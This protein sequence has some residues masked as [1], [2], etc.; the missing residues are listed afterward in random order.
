[1]R[2]IFFLFIHLI[3]LHLF[4]LWYLS[5]ISNWSHLFYQ[6]SFLCSYQSLFRLGRPN[7]V[8]HRHFSCRALW[9]NKRHIQMPFSYRHAC[10]RWCVDLQWSAQHL[11]KFRWWMVDQ[12]PV[13]LCWT[14]NVFAAFRLFCSWLP[15][16][17]AVTKS[18]NM[19]RICWH[20]CPRFMSSRHL[21][22]VCRF[23][24]C[25][26]RSFQLH[27]TEHLEYWGLTAILS[28]VC[29]VTPEEYLLPGITAILLNIQPSP[30]PGH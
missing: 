5:Y 4:Y 9:G 13:D 11:A 10:K 12:M 28:F 25:I 21:N 20:L 14:P 18:S 1:M 16:L 2:L 6:L 27:F 19:R 22:L 3:H 8:I 24:C 23:S 26:V 30:R 15:C 17:L 29:L 7:F